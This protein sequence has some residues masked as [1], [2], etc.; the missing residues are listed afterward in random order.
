MKIKKLLNR[1]LPAVILLAAWAVSMWYVTIA[2]ARELYS[3]WLTMSLDFTKIPCYNETQRIV[4]ELGLEQEYMAYL[5]VPLFGGLCRRYIDPVRHLEASRYYLGDEGKSTI[6]EGRYAVIQ[7]YQR[8]DEPFFRVSTHNVCYMDM[9]AA[10][11]EWERWLSENMVGAASEQDPKWV[12]LQGWFEG[13]RFVPVKAQWS[14]DFSLDSQ[15]NVIFDGSNGEPQPKT[16][17]FRAKEGYD[18]ISSAIQIIDT[19]TDPVRGFDNCQALVDIWA[20]PWAEDKESLLADFNDYYWP[21]SPPLRELQE[22]VLIKGTVNLDQWRAWDFNLQEGRALL[23]DDVNFNQCI[24][25]IRCYPLRSAMVQMIPVYLVSLAV[26]VLTFLLIRRCYSKSILETLSGGDDREISGNHGWKALALLE[27]RFEE[28]SGT[29]QEQTP[30]LRRLETALR[31][32]GDA[33]ENRRKLVS[34][35]THE[36]KTPLAVIHSYAEGLS[37]GIAPEKQETY[38][39]VIMEEAEKMDAMVLSMLD[40][41]RL[42]AGRVRLDREA[43]CLM[44]MSRAV[45]EKLKPLYEEK[46]L[47]VHFLG[48]S[49]DILAD[50]ERMEQMITNLASNAVKY[51]TP[52]GSIYVKVHQ[53]EDMIWFSMEN[54]CYRLPQKALDQIWDSFFREDAARDT[55]GTGLGLPIVKSIVELHGGSCRAVNTDSGLEVQIKLPH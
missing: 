44:D 51:C 33:E 12:E 45:F 19:T 43:V 32:A 47:S 6:P 26:A 41:S 39:R 50:R 36:L 22:T 53:L 13:E 52:T 25:V 34:D 11:P 30:E 10:S 37:M 31:Y 23:E 38:L 35:M 20:N 15:W 24:Q 16:L 54:D 5:E 2:G 3:D 29:L 27:E 4:G 42:E 7:F 55:R 40:L 21:D 49:F 8:E 28:L 9:D 14:D 46:K 1:V 48:E 17:I 18:D